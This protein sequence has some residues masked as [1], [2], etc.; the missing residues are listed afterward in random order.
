MDGGGVVLSA[1]CSRHVSDVVDD[2]GFVPLICCIKL[3]LLL[4]LFRI[5]DDEVRVI[6][7]SPGN[8]IFVPAR[9]PTK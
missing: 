6:V 5:D 1:G 2:V 4:L 9:F 3:L 7:V 8:R